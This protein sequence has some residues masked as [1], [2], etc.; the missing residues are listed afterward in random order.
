[1]LARAFAVPFLQATA[2]AGQVP[3]PGLITEMEFGTGTLNSNSLLY[4]KCQKLLMWVVC[5]RVGHADDG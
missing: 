3:A 4:A 1:M 5:G 2:D